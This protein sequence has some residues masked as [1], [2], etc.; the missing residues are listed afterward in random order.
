[1]A[2]IHPIHPD[3][4]T[5][6]QKSSLLA[7]SQL[8]LVQKSIRIHDP[9]SRFLSG[10][11]TPQSTFLSGSVGDSRSFHMRTLAEMYGQVELLLFLI[12]GT[13]YISLA[14]WV[15]LHYPHLFIVTVH[16]FQLIHNGF[17][18][19]QCCMPMCRRFN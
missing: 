17:N 19:L 12:P 6:A 13:C 14:G 7:A 11:T 3:D 8:L 18:T 4:T 10:I 9:L 16:T 5:P 1:M 15:L 2:H